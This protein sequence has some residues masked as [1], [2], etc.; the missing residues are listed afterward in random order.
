VHR[1][2]SRTNAQEKTSKPQKKKDTVL[3][4]NDRNGSWLF[5]LHG[6]YQNTR[7]GPFYGAER[8][9]PANLSVIPSEITEL[10]PD[11]WIITKPL[12]RLKE[13]SQLPYNNPT[14]KYTTPG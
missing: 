11:S 5:Y 10:L 4:S 12:E 7:E 14:R 3:L 8:K 13:A 1:S 2:A 6:R 9:K